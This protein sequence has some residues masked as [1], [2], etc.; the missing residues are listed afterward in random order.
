VGCVT[1]PQQ[2]TQNRKHIPSSQTN[3]NE[4]LKP[5]RGKQE[6]V[7]R[8]IQHRFKKYS[9]ISL[10]SG[11]QMKP[12]EHLCASTSRLKGSFRGR[13]SKMKRTPRDRQPQSLGALRE[14]PNS[15][16]METQP[17]GKGVGPPTVLTA[18]VLGKFN[19]FSQPWTWICAGC[20]N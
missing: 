7:K 6:P 9:K 18:V 20:T 2:K 14:F 4:L 15:S 19:P 11:F 16:Q 3:C 13:I 10:C 17:S 12:T 8:N 5:R 1:H